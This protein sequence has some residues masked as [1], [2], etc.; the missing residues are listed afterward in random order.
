MTGIQRVGMEIIKEVMIQEP[1]RVGL[2]KI[3]KIAGRFEPLRKPPSFLYPRED[4]ETLHR[5]D[6][7]RSPNQTS[8]VTKPGD[9][10]VAIGASW[11]HWYFIRSARKAKRRH[12][13]LAIMVHDLL[14]LT[15]PQFFKPRDVIAFR[16][17]LE[18]L[19]GLIDLFL[20]SSKDVAI[21]LNRHFV[22]RNWPIPRIDVIRFGAG[23]AVPQHVA[24]IPSWEAPYVLLV[25][26][27]EVRKNHL[28]MVRIWKRLIACY[29]ATKVPQLV[30]VGR[31]GWLVDELMNE[32]ERTQFLFGKITWRSDVDDS[33]LSSAYDHCLFTIFPSRGEGWGLPLTESLR[34]GKFCLSSNRNSLPEAGGNFAEYFDPENFDDAYH[35]VERVLFEPGY[36]AKRTAEIRNGFVSPSWSDTARSL[37]Q[38][39]K[40][41]D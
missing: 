2:V 28:L 26:T 19:A 5:F 7:Q 30:F 22:S 40:R 24:S 14:P 10:L 11:P 20:V 16:N 39:L 9:F 34:H 23:F 6:A 33:G 21:L 1:E 25:S 27:L 32:L 31:R 35:K 8:E 36:L 13:K 15:H 17:G 37:L 41:T 3:A 29:G 18:S 38:A 4:S 12:L